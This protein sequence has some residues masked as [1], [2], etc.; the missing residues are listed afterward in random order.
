MVGLKL[1]RLIERHSETLARGLAEQ[2]RASERTSDFHKIPAEDLQLAAVEVY[3][4]LGEWLL[5]K[6][7]SDIERRFRATAARRAADGICLHQFVWALTL[8]RDHL[9]HFLEREAFA[10][11]IVQLHGELELHRMLNQF[12]DRAVYYGIQGYGDASRQDRPKSS[13][14]LS[15]EGLAASIGLISG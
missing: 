15:L 7:E 14:S 6:T 12:F 11:N 8:T 13:A 1:V 3:R 9:W 4:N 10:D 5:Q 2:I